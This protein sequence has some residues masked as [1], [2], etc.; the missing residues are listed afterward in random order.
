MTKAILLL[1]LVLLLIKSSSSKNTLP[2]GS[3]LSVHHHSDLITSQDNTFTCGFYGFES[4]AYWFAIWFTNSE[5]RTVVWTA[6]RNTPVNGRG[7]KVTF[8]GDGAMVLTD[9]DGMVVWETNTTSTDVNR[10][11]LLDSGNLVL[12]NAKGKILWQSFDYPTDTLLPSQTLTKSKILIS[13]LREGTFESGHF[14]LNYNSINVLTM[15]YDGPEISSVYWPSPDPGFNVWIYGRTSYNSS[16]IAVFNNLGVFNSSDRWQFS[17]SD[18]GFGIKRRL[19]MDHDGNLRIYSL[20]E[21]TRSWSI[22]W[23]AIAKPCDVHGICGRNG[24]CIQG[25]KQ[26]CSCPPGY[27]WSNTTDFTLGCNPTFKKTCGN[28]TSFGFLELPHTDYYGFDLNYSSPIS[29]EACRDI[30]LGDCSCEAFSYRLTGEGFCF[31][32]SALF[33]GFTS[34][35]FPGTIYLKVPRGMKTQSILAGSKPT[36]VDTTITIMVGSPSMYASLKKRVKWVYLYSFALAVGVVEALVILFGWWLFSGKNELLVNLE[37]GYRM[38]S[39]QFRGFS[40]Q[41]L[42]KATQDFKVEIGR[43]GSGAVYK[44]TLEDERVVAVKRVGDVSGEFSA[45]VSTIGQINHMNLVRMWGF[46]SEKKHRLIVYE[47]VENLSLDKRLFSSSFLQWK[48]RFKVAIGIAKGLAYLHHECLEWVIHCDVKPENILLDHA[49]EPK[50][51]DF[52]LAKLFERGGQNSE[53]TKVR[54]TKGYMAPEWAHNLPITA[55]VD[56][57]SYGVVV[58]ELAK[59]I[60]LSSI[61]AHEGEEEEESELTRFVK[62]TK[63]TIQQG[64]ELCIEEIIDPRLGGLFSRH[65]AAKLVEIGLSCVEED[66]NKRPT[67]D[68]VV[69]ILMDCEHEM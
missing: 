25:E 59:G 55:K 35:N 7:S 27:E 22:S 36:C 18:M 4:N 64:N 30:C 61:V 20:N 11:V 44:G 10:A 31:A 58:L 23:Q 34:L 57:Y 56:V 5:D 2:I 14:S 45:E 17:A 24:I 62:V 54:G 50:I 19:T 48:E 37:Y 39:S 1:C 16:R 60:R 52:G 8:R 66:R 15:I 6:N 40:Y 3:S 29:F 47:Y 53:F 68:S 32:K 41:E 69:Q 43:G 49:F 9:V 67:M 42:K 46:C 12:M 33:N 38:I 28:S 65:Q 21:S 13:A 26:E 51:A 63:R